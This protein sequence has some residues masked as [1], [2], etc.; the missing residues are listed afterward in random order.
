[1]VILF[2]LAAF[3][4]GNPVINAWKFDV[5][6]T[7]LLSNRLVTDYKGVLYDVGKRAVPDPRDV[8]QKAL[9][10]AV[11]EEKVRK[12]WDQLKEGPPK[13]V[14]EKNTPGGGKLVTFEKTGKITLK[15]AFQF[16]QFYPLLYGEE[17]KPT[18][19]HVPIGGEDQKFKLTSQTDGTFSLHA[20]R[21][22][23]ATGKEVEVDLSN[24]QD[25]VNVLSDANLKDPLRDT[26]KDKY[27]EALDAKLNN[28]P[29]FKST[30]QK[31]DKTGTVST[32]ERD[33]AFRAASDVLVGSSIQRN[34]LAG[35]RTFALIVYAHPFCARN[36]CRNATPR[37]V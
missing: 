25:P 34:T 23:E 13:A 8:V 24:L 35:L 11:V 1:M 21:T 14:T 26:I 33:K 2:F 27:P 29:D 6:V 18:E 22:D 19:F 37:H 7:V 32:Q 15:E 3:S 5:R 4:L 28:Q 20:V 12:S 17:K 36:S 16:M 9:D 30:L 10:R 31:N